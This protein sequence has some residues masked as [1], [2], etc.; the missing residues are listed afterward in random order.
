MKRTW[1]TVKQLAVQFGVNQDT[2]Y[3]AYRTGKIPGSQMG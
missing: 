3:G 2:V 1:V